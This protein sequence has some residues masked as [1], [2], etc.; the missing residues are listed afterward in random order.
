[1]PENVRRLA[2]SLDALMQY[3]CRCSFTKRILNQ[4]RNLLA[5]K[6]DE[7]ERKKTMALLAKELVKDRPKRRKTELLGHY[8]TSG[9]ERVTVTFL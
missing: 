6:L 4:Y 8:R 9:V 2:L 3:S 1:M 5:E 7:A